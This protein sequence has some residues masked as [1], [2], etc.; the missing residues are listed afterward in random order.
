[1][2]TSLILIDLPTESQK[3]LDL[4]RIDFG[5]KI[6]FDWVTNQVPDVNI[7][8]AEW[9]DMTFRFSKS[10]FSGFEYM[11]TSE[12]LVE[13]P[14]REEK[15]CLITIGATVDQKTIKFVQRKLT[16]FYNRQILIVNSNNLVNLTDK[17]VLEKNL[18]RQRY[19]KLLS[20]AELVISNGGTTLAECLLLKK[21]TIVV[22]KNKYEFNFSLIL[23]K[24]YPILDIWQNE[25]NFNIIKLS[26]D[27]QIKLDCF[28]V[29]RVGEII[30]QYI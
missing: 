10:K 15:Y 12:E 27:K 26:S 1:M 30:E 13:L 23:E 24:H 11:V 5:V 9:A 19:L 6:C 22:P 20:E 8:V 4:N 28:G 29:H 2:N 18:T 21:Q 14:T 17:T 16:S 3:N 25:T 7:I